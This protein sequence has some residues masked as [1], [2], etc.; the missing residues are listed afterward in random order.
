MSAKVIV[1]MDDADGKCLISLYFPPDIE[2][3]NYLKGRVALSGQEEVVPGDGVVVAGAGAIAYVMGVK[4]SANDNVKNLV[5]WAVLSENTSRHDDNDPEWFAQ[6][7]TTAQSGIDGA[8]N[9]KKSLEAIRMQ[10]DMAIDS[11]D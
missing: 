3:P 11:C 6:K 10:I 5:F 7:V 2:H 9:L 1:D 4:K 8:E